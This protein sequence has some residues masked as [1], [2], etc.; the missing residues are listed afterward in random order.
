MSY[1]SL[2]E[3]L[4]I[5]EITYKQVADKQKSIVRL[6]P[7]FHDRVA[8]VKAH[9]GTQLTKVEGEVWTFRVKSGDDA[10]FK[11]GD[12]YSVRVFF[13]NV[14][15]AISEGAAHRDNWT[16]DGKH[17][18]LSKLGGW[19]VFHCDLAFS[20]NCKA[21]QF[22]GPNYQRTQIGAEL[23]HDEQ[24][25]PNIRNP[26]QDGLNCKHVQNLADTLPFYGQ[27]FAVEVLKKYFSKFILDLEKK[28]LA[29]RFN[30]KSTPQ[31]EPKEE[32]PVTNA[33]PKP[34]APKEPIKKLSPAQD[35]ENDKFTK[36]EENEEEQE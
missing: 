6:F 28:I 8:K 1:S 22:W 10:R 27:T 11:R 32:K 14:E 12:V 23:D 13:D 29:K 36:G 33:Q 21:S 5:K 16:K 3:K 4:T 25:P 34:V 15:K 9:G 18:N 7:S 2:I 35:L 30:S 17:L 20:C 19:C 26:N 31:V 24:R